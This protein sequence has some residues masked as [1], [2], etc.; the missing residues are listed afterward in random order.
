MPPRVSVIIPTHNDAEY[1]PE[2]V[3]SALEEGRGLD[4][5]V[6]VID[7]ASEPPTASVYRPPD[8]RV[9]IHSSRSRGV[10]AARNTGLELATGDF[11]FFLDAD[12]RMLPGRVSGQLDIL[13]R[14]PEFALV[15]G[16]IT[17]RALDGTEESWGIF[18]AFGE[19]LRAR[20]SNGDSWLFDTV[21]RDRVLFHYPFNTSVM[22]VRREFLK[23]AKLAFDPE[24]V[25]WEDWDFVARV[26]RIGHVAYLRRP[27]CLY[28]KRPGSITTSSDPRKFLSRARMFNK[29]RKDFSDLAPE[30]RR[31]LKRQENEAWLSAAHEFRSTSRQ[32]A[33]ACACRA[34]L[35][36]PRMKAA[37]SILG[38]LKP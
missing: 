35:Q 14:N 37:R 19:A 16:D 30:T 33:L 5:E 21:F 6:L 23:T 7:D 2:S 29:W 12:D 34:F 26:A 13:Y 1:L 4:M 32:Q 31:L 20:R 9:S 18:E 28:R 25:C 8:S 36:A 15:G 27:V 3:G 24:L 17:R 11:V 22:A 38:S 10:S